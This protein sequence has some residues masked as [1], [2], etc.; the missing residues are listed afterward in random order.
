LTVS[1]EGPATLDAT[2][3]GPG[4]TLDAEVDAFGFP[5]TVQ[6]TPGT[7]LTI[8]FG[9]R[10]RSAS[11]LIDQPAG[12]T[13]L[14]EKVGAPPAAGETPEQVLT[15][16]GL[17][18]LRLALAF[19]VVGWLFLLIAAGLRAR[20]RAMNFSLAL[21]RVAIGALLAIDLPLAS[22][23]VFA[24]GLPIGI[25]WLGIM[26]LIAFA[27]L[28]ALGYAYAGFQVGRLVLDMLGGDAVPWALAVPLGV[29]AIVLLGQIPVVG[30]IV[31][32]I[33][34]LYGIGALVYAPAERRA[35]SAL[36]LEAERQAAELPPAAGRP[37]VN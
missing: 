4:P 35:V 8:G 15:R 21:R 5:I 33:V 9:Q 17:D 36:P 10:V 6:G 32:L 23:V 30:G 13:G 26:G 7:N 20:A 11:L 25:W 16:L 19:T 31:S 1:G 12:D 22:L 3:T 24:V 18:W 14:A 27:A 37:I 2:L 28:A 29:A 34:T